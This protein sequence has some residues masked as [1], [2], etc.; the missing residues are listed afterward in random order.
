MRNF[1]FDEMTKF[2]KGAS[3]KK[4][5]TADAMQGAM[6]VESTAITITQQVLASWPYPCIVSL[7]RLFP[8]GSLSSETSTRARGW[9]SGQLAV[10]ATA[11]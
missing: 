4:S 9:L 10:R 3:D 7:A 1:A 11:S 8:P 2:S 6:W 5:R